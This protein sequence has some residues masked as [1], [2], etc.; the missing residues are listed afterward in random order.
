[1]SDMGGEEVPQ[2]PDPARSGRRVDAGGKAYTV[3]FAEVGSGDPVVFVHGWAVGPGPYLESLSRLADHGFRVVAPDLTRLGPHWRVSDAVA[4]LARVVEERV[5]KPTAIVGHSLGGGIAALYCGTHRNRVSRLALINTIGASSLPHSLALLGLHFLPYISVSRWRTAMGFIETAHSSHGRQSVTDALRWLRGENLEPEL[6][7]LA[8]RH[9]PATVVWSRGD[10][11][12][13]LRCGET[14]AEKLCAPL[15]VVDGD[16]GWL[17]Q[18]PERFAQVISEV[19]RPS[20]AE[21][22]PMRLRRESA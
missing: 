13:P 16:H 3:A 6:E 4:S 17:L 12:V 7:T 20:R 9:L 15:V 5:E 18:D 10:H 2:V 22:R 21:I 19:L 11:L 8:R 1:M 14:I